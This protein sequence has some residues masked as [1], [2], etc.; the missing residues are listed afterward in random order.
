MPASFPLWCRSAPLLTLVMSATAWHAVGLSAETGSCCSTVWR[1]QKSD[2]FEVWTPVSVEAKELAA[3]LE[4]NIERQRRA[5][6]KEGTHP[7]QPKCVVVVHGTLAGY[8]RA[9]GNMRDASVGMSTFAVEKG[10]IMSRRIDLRCDA[11]GW[12]NDAL[13]HELTHLVLADVFDARPPARWIDEGLAV[14]AESG[15]KQDRRAAV[16]Q[17]AIAGR[18]TI[19]TTELLSLER[20]PAAAQRD[21][22]YSQSASLAA[23]LVKREGAAEFCEFVRQSRE[24]G[25]D[26]ALRE[27]YGLEG[28]RHLERL[29]QADLVAPRT[30]PRQAEQLVIDR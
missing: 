30:V 2:N 22:F 15:R 18:A 14:L 21:L 23:Y 19:P 5:W 12:M 28:T 13:P 20:I 8:Q 1:C 4:A 27:V 7:W 26:M 24:K 29:W 11:D 6:Q 25:A 16:L 17:R 9:I 10:K 3:T